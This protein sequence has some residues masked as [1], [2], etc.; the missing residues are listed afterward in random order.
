MTSTSARLWVDFDRTF[1]GH[2][3]GTHQPFDSPAVDFMRQEP[4][5]GHAEVIGPAG[6]ARPTA[7]TPTSS[8]PSRSE[9]SALEPTRS[10]WIRQK[11]DDTR[12]IDLSQ[13]C[14]NPIHLA[15]EVRNGHAANASPRADLSTEETHALMI[16]T[17]VPHG[18]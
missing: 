10:R 15:P 5:A 6:G 14:G 1:P 9:A 17:K 4:G 7:P 18:K 2:R 13:A 3:D 8:S 12:L 11:L 16:D